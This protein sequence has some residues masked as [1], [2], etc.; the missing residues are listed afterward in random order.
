MTSRPRKD[1]KEA[2]LDPSWMLQWM[3]PERSS[4]RC[5]NQWTGANEIAAEKSI[6]HLRLITPLAP[7]HLRLAVPSPSRTRAPTSSSLPCRHGSARLSCRDA[8]PG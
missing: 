3:T 4:E 5:R 7:L 8:T 1:R 6:L 2:E